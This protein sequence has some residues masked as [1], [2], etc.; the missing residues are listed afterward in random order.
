M[1]PSVSM[2]VP[3]EPTTKLKTRNLQ[4]AVQQLVKQKGPFNSIT[5]QRLQADLELALSKP[6]VAED[7]ATSEVDENV[8]IVNKETQQQTLDRLYRA[9]Q[10]MTTELGQVQQHILSLIDTM[11]FAIAAQSRIG[12]AAISPALR[13]TAPLGSIE[14]KVVQPR[15]QSKK[16]ANLRLNDISNVTR[17]KAFQAASYALTTAS[18]RLEKESQRQARYWEQMATL[19]KNGWSV[20]RL[21]NDDRALVVHFVCAESGSQY[22]SKGIATLRQQENGNLTLPDQSNIQRQKTLSVTVRRN[23]VASGFYS[24]IP[25]NDPSRIDIETELFRSRETLFQ[26][27]LFNEASREARLIAS[28]GVKTRQS[29]IEIELSPEFFLDLRYDNKS[30]KPTSTESSDERLASFFG[31]GLRLMLTAEHRHKLDLR[32]RSAP[33]PMTQQYRSPPEYAIIRPLLAQLRHQVIATQL[34]DTLSH[35]QSSLNTAGLV[36]SFD[37]MQDTDTEKDSK[38]LEQLRRPVISVIQMILPSKTVLSLKMQTHLAAPFFGTHILQTTYTNKCGTVS[39][40][41]STVIADVQNFLDDVIA[42]EVAFVGLGLEQTDTKWQLESQFPPKFRSLGNGTQLTTCQI[43]CSR[44]IVNISFEST[45]KLSRRVHYVAETAR[46][47]M[48]G[49]EW[50][51]TS[52]SLQALLKEWTS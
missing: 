3:F 45:D 4:N 9:R 6:N 24:Y 18:T 31:D 48:Q 50:E 26:E 46:V 17:A 15:S 41:E 12:E 5:E 8:S 49:A 14:T 51:N 33:V 11:S 21:P 27:E 40:P 16:E 20:S 52:L 29:C 39:C 13:Q 42:Q 43:T 10:Q 25:E 36:L 28:M 32:T 35:Y 44:G 30:S 2:T 37:H 23:G 38:R 47:S 7:D 19:R 22:K 34:L 1:A